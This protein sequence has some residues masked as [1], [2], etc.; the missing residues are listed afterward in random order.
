MPF[1]PSLRVQL[2]DT[3]ELAVLCD[4]CHHPSAEHSSPQTET[5]H[6]SNTS[7]HAPLSRPP[8]TSAPSSVSMNCLITLCTSFKWTYVMF[9]F[10]DWLISL[11]VVSIFSRFAH[12]VACIET[13]LTFTTELKSHCKCADCVDWFTYQWALS[14]PYLLTTEN[15]ATMTWVCKYLLECCLPYLGV[16]PRSR[17]PESYGNPPFDFLRGLRAVFHSGG[18]CFTFP[19]TGHKCFS[20]ITSSSALVFSV[21]FFLFAF[22]NSGHPNGV[23]Q[24]LIVV[25][26]AFP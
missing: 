9:V 8:V 24:C 12:A 4:Q 19:E 21:L 25:W 14:L 16:T 2:S 11:G 18:N 7:L 1:W 17:I 26:S 15:D 13:S 5:P 22:F 23:K 3:K 20:F 10:C 6:P